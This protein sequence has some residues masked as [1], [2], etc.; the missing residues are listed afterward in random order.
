M[1]YATQIVDALA[2]AHA[3]GIVHRDL[4]L[5]NIM[6]AGGSVKVLDFG[7]ATSSTPVDPQVPRTC[8]VN[9]AFSSSGGSQCSHV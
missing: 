9:L 7:I 3:H 8:A 1:R 2:G 6:V 5:G 4:K